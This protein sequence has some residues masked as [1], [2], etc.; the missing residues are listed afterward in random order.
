MP[1]RYPGTPPATWKP[2]DGMPCL[3]NP[4]VHNVAVEFGRIRQVGDYLAVHDNG[5]ITGRKYTDTNLGNAQSRTHLQGIQRLGPPNDNFVLFTSGDPDART[6]HLMVAHL[7]SRRNDYPFGSN[8]RFSRKPPAEDGLVRLYALHHKYWHA[9]GMSLLGDLLALPLEDDNDGSSAIA[10]L[11]VTDPLDVRMFPAPCFIERPPDVGK[12]GAVAFT[13]LPNRHYLCAMWSDSDQHPRRF[14]FY[15]SVS[16][17]ITEGFRPDFLSWT[18]DRLLP[19]GGPPSA[20]QN[21][22][23]I[24]QPDGELFMIGTENTSDLSPYGQGDDHADLLHVEFP[25]TT[26]HDFDPDLMTPTITRIATKAVIGERGYGNLD[27]AGGIH[28]EADWSAGGAEPE[29]RLNLYSAY[30][31][32]LSR[33]FRFIEYGRE[34]PASSPM[35]EDIEDAWIDLY[36]DPNFRGRRLSIFGTGDEAIRDYDRVFVQD[37]GFGDKVSAVRFQIPAGHTYRLFRDAGF[38][39]A[40]EARSISL[41]GDG[42]VHEIPDLQAASGFGDQ[43]SSSKYDPIEV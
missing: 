28:I 42:F 8:L 6:S 9:G 31:W 10:F 22:N 35:I 43:I 25:H 5:L 7:G 38:K 12:G 32:R 17:D 2:T 19:A 3:D 4:T 36:D 20:W 16:P 23:F 18:I 11:D 24:L 29:G 34:R 39:P 14:D 37:R 21:V 41:K 27:A 1:D 40:S 30:H 13:R 15:L 26:T 33:T